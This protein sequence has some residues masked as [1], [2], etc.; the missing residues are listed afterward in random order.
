MAVFVV[1][2]LVIP[3]F[4]EHQYSLPVHQYYASRI[5]RN[6]TGMSALYLV[7]GNPS[8]KKHIFSGFIHS[9]QFGIRLL[10]LDLNHCVSVVPFRQQ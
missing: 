1:D 10:C 6:T 5:Y 9:K 4:C 8:F 3:D 7:G 2:N